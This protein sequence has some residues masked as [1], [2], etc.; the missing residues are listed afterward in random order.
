[1]PQAYTK[2][3]GNRQVPDPDK[4]LYNIDTFWFNADAINYQEVMDNWLREKLVSARDTF[5]DGGQSKILKLELSGY[6]EPIIFEIMGGQPPAYQY[7]IRNSDIAIYFAKN[8]RDNQMPMKVQ[9]NQFILW[10]KGLLDAVTEAIQVLYALGLEYSQGQLNRVDFCV[11]SDQWQW[12]LKDLEKFKYPQNFAKDNYPLFYR[13]DP[14]T[15]Y[16]E[17]ALYGDREYLACR[18]YNKSIE[19]KKKSKDYFFEIYKHYGLDPENVWNV[20][21]ECRR[22]FIKQLKDKENIDFFDDLITVIRENRLDYLWTYLMNECYS[23][24]SAFW[25]E[26]SKGGCGNFQNIGYIQDTMIRNRDNDANFMREVA[27]IRGRLMTALLNENSLSIYDAIDKFL[28]MNRIYEEEKE[29][30]W[31]EELLN[32]KA[33][34]HNESINETIKI[35]KQDEIEQAKKRE[36][37]RIKAKERLKPRMFMNMTEAERKK[38]IYN[39]QY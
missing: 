27:Q 8:Q 23:H 39:S 13:L 24:N 26:L 33:S 6:D 4:F 9:I 36:E 28:E 10:E 25:T 12:V 21:F 29:R 1:M 31:S 22:D 11:H 34:Y 32:K 20:E 17:T 38:H 14:A 15:G 2:K 37:N 5:L 19:A 16:F 35:V 18:I 30:N 3:W 7:S